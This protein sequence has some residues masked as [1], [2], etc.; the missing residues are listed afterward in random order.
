MSAASTTPN[1][2]VYL[3]YAA[4]TPIDPRVA[5]VMIE[6]LQAADLCGN[7]SSTGH[8]FGRR[9]RALV[10]AARKQVATLINAKPENIVWTSGATESN[11]MALLGAARFHAGRGRHIVSARTE[12]KAVLDPLKRLEREGFEVTYL[13]PDTSGIVQPEQVIA[14]FRPDTVLVS[15]MQVNN[16]TGVIQDVGAVGAACRERGVLFHVDAAQGAGKVAIDVEA[17]GIDLMSLT[18]HKVY[19][20]KGVG[21]LYLRR[22]PPLG[23][24]PLI[25]GGGQEGGLRS[26]TLATHQIVGMGRAFELAALE[27]SGDSLRLT[28]LRDRLWRGLLAVGGVN[29]NGHPQH[30]IPGVL[31]VAFSDIEGESLQFA[32]RDLAV[33]A[34]AACSSDSEEA[35]YVL[36]A[37]G[38]TDAEARSSLR[39]SLGRFT[40]AADIE[41]AVECVAREV[42]RLRALTP[43]AA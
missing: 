27:G 29:L 19:G 9:A 42:P 30:R 18:A 43:S 22:R 16:E 34:G 39:F 15:L 10:E 23:L 3:D 24:T 13:K 7:P 31:N 37:L 20:P 33:S 6:C 14:A 5:A 40:T 12:H 25:E 4:T 2:P 26:G 17:L 1:L 28:D 35:S 38:R 41:F 21:A 8:A 32:L 11:N 36:R